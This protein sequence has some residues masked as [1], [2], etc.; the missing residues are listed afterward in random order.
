MA[1]TNKDP[2]NLRETVKTIAL[3]VRIVR[4]EARGKPTKRLEKRVDRIREQAQAR[5]D[6]KNTSTSKRK[7]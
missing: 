5:E 2:H 1:L 3:G 6:A 7:K 4:R